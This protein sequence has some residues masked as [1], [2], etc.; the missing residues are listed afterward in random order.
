MIP[1][2]HQDVR[3]TRKISGHSE[4]VLAQDCD[5]V[6]AVVFILA[7]DTIIAKTWPGD[8]ETRSGPGS[9]GRA[10]V[11]GPGSGSQGPARPPSSWGP[12][13]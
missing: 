9:V 5:A 8:V 7:G 3:L 2:I 1:E 12:F 13:T 6:L 10:R 4:R 11:P